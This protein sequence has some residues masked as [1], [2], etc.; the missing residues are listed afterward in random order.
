MGRNLIIVKQTTNSIKLYLKNISSVNVTTVCHIVSFIGQTLDLQI[1]RWDSFRIIQY[2]VEKK[3][4]SYFKWTDEE[5]VSKSFP[6][7]IRTQDLYFE[8]P[9]IDH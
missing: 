7:R 4:L 9:V 1:S 6:S 2:K 5:D 8:S 3:K